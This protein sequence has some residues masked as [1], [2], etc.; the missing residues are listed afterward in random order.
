MDCLGCSAAVDGSATNSQSARSSFVAF[1]CCGIACRAR[2]VAVLKHNS[3]VVA[4]LVRWPED[5][6][7]EVMHLRQHPRRHPVGKQG[8]LSRLV[9]AT[10]TGS[11]QH[12]RISTVLS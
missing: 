2:P 10:V 4:S 9:K 1:G 12:G 3:G 5:M 11:P 6:W 8:T 7:R